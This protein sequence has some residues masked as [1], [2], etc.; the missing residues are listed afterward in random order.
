MELNE[1]ATESNNVDTEPRG[2]HLLNGVGDENND[3]VVS[4]DA[5]T[6]FSSEDGSVKLGKMI[7]QQEMP[8]NNQT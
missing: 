5:K 3:E 8:S 6:V 1:P 2:M 7:Q 4:K